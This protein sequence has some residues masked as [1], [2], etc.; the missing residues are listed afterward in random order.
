MAIPFRET[1]SG[2]SIDAGESVGDALSD[3]SDVAGIVLR[4]P[5]LLF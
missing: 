3:S 4:D 2:S 5:L 1:I